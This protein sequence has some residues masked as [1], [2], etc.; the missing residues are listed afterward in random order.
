MAK[1]KKQQ[2][3]QRA[4]KGAIGEI[5]TRYVKPEISPMPDDKKHRSRIILVD[6]YEEKGKLR[7]SFRFEDGDETELFNA[8]YRFVTIIKEGDPLLLFDKNEKVNSNSNEFEEPNISWKKS[9]ARKK[10]YK[11]VMEGRV[12]LEGTA[13]TTDFSS[14]YM[15]HPEYAAWNFDTFPR[16]LDGI[17]EIIKKKKQRAADDQASFELYVKNNPVSLFSYHG[18]IQWQGSEAQMQVKKDL[19]NGV[20]ESYTKEKYEHPKMA[21]WLTKD[22]F[23]N[24]FPLPVF[25]DKIK[26]EIRTGKY[27]HTLKVRGKKATYKYAA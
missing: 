19:A 21:Y 26:Q 11:D 14:I 5:L 2:R 9:V 17:R 27:L 25:R 24:E 4:G 8:S 7:Y 16:R 23:F 12:P 10:L 18:Y 6:R 15:M 13:K 22:F 3:K 1:T 20:L